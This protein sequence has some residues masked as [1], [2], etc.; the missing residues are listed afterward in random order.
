MSNEKMKFLMMGLESL[1][2]LRSAIRI[3]SVPFSF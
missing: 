1:D 3:V 2:Y